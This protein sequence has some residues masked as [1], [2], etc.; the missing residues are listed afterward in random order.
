MFVSMNML[1]RVVVVMVAPAIVVSVMLVM[2]SV[3]VVVMMMA[4]MHLEADA[5]DL[6]SPRPR[7][8]QVVSFEAQLFQLARQVLHRR[9]EVEHG[10]HEHVA[11]DPAEN[12]QVKRFHL[13]SALI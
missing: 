12:V 5:F 8:M 3:I 13:A 9:A 2:V 6:E 7:Y 11:A 10:A 1:M 4:D